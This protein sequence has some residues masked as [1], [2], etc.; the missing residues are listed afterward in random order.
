[1]PAEIRHCRSLTG[2]ILEIGC[3]FQAGDTTPAPERAG[4]ATAA[5]HDAVQAL[6]DK[7]Q[8]P[9]KDDSEKRT[10]SRLQYHGKVE[11]R[12]S[13]EPPVLGFAR[14]LSKGGVGF[15]TTVAVPCAECVIFLAQGGGP[16]L[17]IRAHV[18]RCAK[19]K[20]GL[21][22]VGAHFLELAQ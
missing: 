15:L 19:I 5:V 1:M 6:L 8:Q 10:Y 9:P 12:R 13:G 18:Q 2:D 17:G 20:E 4:G 16:A 7:I 3:R 14:D 21:Y 22:D 11:V